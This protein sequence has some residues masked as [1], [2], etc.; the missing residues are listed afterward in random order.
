MN[1]TRLIALAALA[2]GIGCAAP[3]LAQPAK[4]CFR[5]SQLQSTRPDGDRRI[6]ARVGVNE[7]WRIDLAHRCSSLP[8]PNTFLV[9]KP[10]GGNDV[11]CSPIDLDL[12]VNDNGANEPCFISSFTKLTPEEVAAIPKRSKP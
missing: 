2:A 6:Y 8:Y 7:Y 11:I 9:L 3:A 1:R 10:A 12:K 5:L 4:S